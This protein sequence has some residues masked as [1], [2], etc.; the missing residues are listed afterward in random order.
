MSDTEQKTSHVCNGLL[1]RRIESPPKSTAAGL[2]VVIT[3][4]EPDPGDRLRQW[5][6][7]SRADA[8]DLCPLCDGRG[9]F[10]YVGKLRDARV[11]NTSTCRGCDG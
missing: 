1:L 11:P 6:P 10:G 4:P 5:I 2:I 8:S 3:L 7:Q 9:R